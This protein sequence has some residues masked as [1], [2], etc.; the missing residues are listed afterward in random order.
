[1]SFVTPQ[2]S[3]IHRSHIFLHVASSIIY[4]NYLLRCLWWAFSSQL[5]SFWHLVKNSSC[6]S[7]TLWFVILLS[8]PDLWKKAEVVPLNNVKSPQTFKESLAIH[9]RED[10]PCTVMH[11]QHTY[12]A[13]IATTDSLAKFPADIAINLD[14]AD[15]IAVQALQL[16][17]STAL[18]RGP[19]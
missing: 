1:M 3:V 4:Q 5:R 19:I 18:A 10:L 8:N 16:D 9:I 17:F 7:H 2:R 6:S 15:N 14:N 12:N 11:N 13:K